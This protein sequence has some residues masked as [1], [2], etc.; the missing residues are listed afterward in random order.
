[1]PAARLYL[2]ELPP[3]LADIV[4]GAVASA[5]GI[6]VVGEGR[7][8]DAGSCDADVVLAEAAGAALPAP[9]DHLLFR[10]PRMRLLTLSPDGR[11]AALW[12]LVPER[13]ALEEA[14]PRSLVEALR[15]AAGR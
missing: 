11:T 3:L 15:A 6:E 13:R 1:M 12:R 4:R 5:A 8:S 10:N 7:T 2:A 9:L 14:S